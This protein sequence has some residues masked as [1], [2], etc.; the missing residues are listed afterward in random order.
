MYNGYVLDFFSS[1]NVGEI[2]E[3]ISYAHTYVDIPH[4]TPTHTNIEYHPRW[5]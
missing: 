1:L 4:K 5:S 3:T 2:V